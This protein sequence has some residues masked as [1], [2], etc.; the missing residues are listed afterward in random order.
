MLLA[1][2][3]V[4]QSFPQIVM[5]EAK[6][7]TTVPATFDIRSK[8]FGRVLKIRLENYD[9]RTDEQHALTRSLMK[10]RARTR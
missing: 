7:R 8:N 3:K 10:L 1:T 2:H 6:N 5:I 9:L 4:I